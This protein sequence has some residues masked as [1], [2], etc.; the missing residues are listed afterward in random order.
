MNF[1]NVHSEVKKTWETEIVHELS[2]YI[3]VPNQ[4]PSFDPE[5]ATNGLLER[6]VAQ[7]VEWVKKQNV[8]GLEYEVVK[9]EGRT[10]LLFMTVPATCQSDETILFYG[11][12]DK[13]PPMDGTWSEGLGPYTPVIRNGKLY[14]RGGADDGYAAFASITAIRALQKQGIPHARCVIVIE[15]C[16][17][18]GSPDLA[19]YIDLLAPKIGTPSLIVCL[20]SGAGNYEQMWLTT[21]LRG[22]VMGKLTVQ[23]LRESVHSGH[24]S[25]IVP[26]SFRIARQLLDRI[27]DSQTGRILLPE[28]HTDI[29]AE[30][31]EQNK[32][33]AEALGDSVWTEFAYAENPCPVHKDVAELL[34]NRTWRPA[35]AVTGAEGLPSYT[36]A[37]NVMRTHT[38]LK[39]SMRIPAHV[40]PAVAAN[41][42][43]TALETNPP[44]GAKVTFE[45][46][47]A[48]S[49]WDAPALSSWLSDSLN[50]ASNK[51]FGKPVG[52]LGE[53]GSIPF[54]GMLS[55]KFPKAQFV[56]TGVLG[57]ESN[58][59]GPNEFLDI[60]YA[61]NLTTC[62]SS[63]VSDHCQVSLKK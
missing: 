44:H 2:E 6:V 17:E 21:S 48:A 52:F 55:A 31:I 7:A 42:L 27:E 16:E 61:T 20:D 50:K 30:R 37:G 14:G 62:I 3:K 24:G 54:M 33:T 43:K 29:P 22:L 57:P 36:N 8:T 34:L 15:C 41:A 63:I 46:A 19:F 35:L 9:V 39:L 13:Q 32:A 40:D 45:P 60:A 12:L 25:G 10:P 59:H 53:G 58:A 11:H 23:V 4:S 56:I 26:S 49:G 28:L 1:D 51:F 18:S 47:Q 38:V 5:W